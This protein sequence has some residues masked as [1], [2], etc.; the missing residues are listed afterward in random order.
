MESRTGK[1]M[2][3]SLINSLERKEDLSK[4]EKLML[5]PLPN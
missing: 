2:M 4:E 1:I 3:I 5:N